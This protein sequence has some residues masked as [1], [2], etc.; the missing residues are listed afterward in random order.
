MIPDVKTKPTPIKLYYAH[1][2]PP[3]EVIDALEAG[4][5]RVS[6]RAEIYESDGETRWNPDRETDED[7]SRLVDG[8][9]TV[10]YG[11][12]ERR[13]LDITLDNKDGLLRP[14]PGDGFWYDKIIKVFR[15]IEYQS[16]RIAPRTAIIEAPTDLAGRKLATTLSGMGFNRTSYVPLATEPNDLNKYSFIVAYSGT[17]ATTKAALL[18]ELWAAGKNIVTIGLGNGTAQI[19][20]ISAVTVLGGAATWG[21]T[22]ASGDHP[23]KGAFTSQQEGAASAGTAPTGLAGGATSLSAWNT[24]TGTTAITASIAVTGKGAYW[25]N[26]QL[27]DVTAAQVIAMT[28]AALNFMRHYHST[29]KW[30]IQQGEFMI[31]NINAD[32]F[33]HNIKVT[34]RD[35]TKK[36]LGSKVTRSLSFA[37]GTSI[38]ELIRNVAA[39]AGIDATKMRIGVSGSKKLGTEMSFERGTDRWTIIKAVCDAYNYEI[40]FDARGFLIVR[41]Y[42]DPT[43]G[44][45]SWTF[46]TGLE[47]DPDGA[48]LVSYSRAMSDSRIYNHI[49][50]QSDPSEGEERLPYYGE[51]KNENADSPT[52]MERLGDRMLPI[53]ANWLS[54][55]AEC[56]QLAKDRLKIAALESYDVQF[57]SLYYPWMEVGEVYYVLDPERLDIEPTRFLVDGL[58]YPLGL[59]PMSGSAKRVT[60][61]GSPGAPDEVIEGT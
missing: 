15:G 59:G 20:F 47:D 36:L 17:G 48:N 14:N 41:K 52:R 50:V 34:G 57:S 43:T 58:T 53:Q 60:Y 4:V 51:A 18:A 38:K 55:D 35:Y 30:E 3:Q 5:V 10:D 29:I 19:P 26:L 25:L 54:S 37:V 8:A 44:P 49:V 2:E 45:I 21:V 23:V 31:D 39:N 56:E 16:K 33:P 46:K 11:S 24:G 40:F 61:V 32:H 22:S 6:R 27:P 13:K 1:G 12:A 42:I 28:K 7:F 9:V